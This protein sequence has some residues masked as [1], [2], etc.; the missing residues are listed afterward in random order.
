MTMLAPSQAPQ[1]A[2][3]SPLA[4]RFHWW[5]VLFV[6]V[7]IPM[8]LYMTYRGG[9]L[10]VFDVVT[11]T[12]YDSHKLLG[13]VIFLLVIARLGYRLVH[14]APPDEPTL[15]WWQKS[16]SHATHWGLYLM[17]LVVPMLGYIGIS[18]YPALAVFDIP[19]PAITPSD[20]AAAQRVFAAH[21]LGAILLL[22]LVGAH[23]GAALFHYLI[24][25]D[26]VLARMLPAAGRRT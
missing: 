20:M 22:L 5:T 19:L 17:L 23:V 26:G 14:G 1:D 12:L 6:A 15:K 18:L 13:L 25:R 11:N 21:Y 10:N 24:R 8:G 2:T 4:R 3:Y 16:A 9:V 7:Q